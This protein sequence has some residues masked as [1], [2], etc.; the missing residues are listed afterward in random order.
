MDPGMQGKRVPDLV[1]VMDSDPGE[2]P[3]L[4][5]QCE[6]VLEAAEARDLFDELY[7]GRGPA[8]VTQAHQ[9]IKARLGHQTSFFQQIV[10]LAFRDNGSTD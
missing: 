5:V 4:R 1:M 2:P 6:I 10:H 3:R 8:G 9:R 7:G